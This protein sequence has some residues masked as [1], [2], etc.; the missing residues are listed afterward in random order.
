L[1]RLDCM[2]APV[3]GVLF[4]PARFRHAGSIRP[5]DFGDSYA[6]KVN[7]RC[8]GTSRADVDCRKE[9]ARVPQ[10]AQPR[11]NWCA[12]TRSGSKVAMKPFKIP[13]P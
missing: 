1:Q 5:S 2:L 13:V 12:A 7:D 3:Q 11:T 4:S 9:W 10:R 8:A 6:V